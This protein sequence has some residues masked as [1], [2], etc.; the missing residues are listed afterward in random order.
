MENFVQYIRKEGRK[1]YYKE[2]IKQEDGSYRLSDKIDFD[3]LISGIM[4]S[5]VRKNST[6]LLP[7]EQMLC[8]GVMSISLLQDSQFHNLDRNL[9]FQVA[10]LIDFKPAP[11]EQLGGATLFEPKLIQN[12]SSDLFSGYVL[13]YDCGFFLSFVFRITDQTEAIPPN[14]ILFTLQ[15]ELLKETSTNQRLAN[16]V[17]PVDYVWGNVNAV[18]LSLEIVNDMCTVRYC[19]TI[20][21]DVRNSL[22]NA[23][24]L[25]VYNHPKY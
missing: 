23:F 20:G 12:V 16:F 17:V 5:G 2:L 1:L 14:G 21:V 13:V 3:H 19:K 10:D 7:A 6:V 18:V 24:L 9:E 15:S 4:I 11:S 8:T 25:T 22:N